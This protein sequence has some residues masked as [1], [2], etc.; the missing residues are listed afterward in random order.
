MKCSFV[1]SLRPEVMRKFSRDDPVDELHQ[2]VVRLAR[3][4]KKKSLM[5]QCYVAVW[6]EMMY[7]VWRHRCLVMYDG[8]RP[9]ATQ[10][11]RNV[12]FR[13]A[14]R[15]QGVVANFLVD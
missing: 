3:I 8:S 13:V 14:S 5:A 12:R 7:E 11:I 10:A 4:A 15:F 9:N 2:Q 6:T 1:T